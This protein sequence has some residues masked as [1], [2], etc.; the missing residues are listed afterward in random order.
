MRTNSS[1]K[2]IAKMD[3]SEKEAKDDASYE[4]G[5]IASIAHMMDKRKD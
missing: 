2:D 3:T 5:S 4:K 1:V